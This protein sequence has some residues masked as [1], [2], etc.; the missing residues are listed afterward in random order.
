MLELQQNQLVFSFPNVHAAA[1]CSIDFQRTLRLPDDNREYPLPP[2]LGNF[3][4]LHIDDYA[5]KVPA[6]WQEHG[7]VFMPMY[8]AEAMWLNFSSEYPFAIKI[9]AGKINAVTGEAWKNQ[10]QVKPQDYMVIPEQPWLDGFC[11][12]K[13]K[14]RQFIAMALGK[15]YTAEEQITGK[16]EHGGLQIIA[17]P[18]KAK[19]YEQLF[20]QRLEETMGRKKCMPA[21]APMET[22]ADMEMGLAPGGLMTQEIYDDPY[23]IDAW[24]TNAAARC[25]VHIVNSEHF[26][27]ITG[28]APPHLPPSA[29]DYTNS[30]LPWF[31]YYGG[32]KTALEGAPKL[33]QLDSVAAKAIKQNEVIF[34]DNT[35][36]SPTNVVTVGK[37]GVRDGDWN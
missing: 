21:S 32:D 28:A 16:A 33:S 34:A 15:G 27:K 10:L 12:S 2:G 6:H 30:G 35:A 29:S 37:H 18:M 25:F 31:D 7:G 9:A 20:A 8:Q 19:I 23:G 17:Y 3:P 36:V 1:R 24:D 11:V 4:L 5:A 22:C 13:G 26:L 14:I